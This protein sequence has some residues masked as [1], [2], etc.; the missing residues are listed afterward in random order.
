[1]VRVGAIVNGDEWDKIDYKT[2]ELLS[3]SWSES[4]PGSWA[5][6]YGLISVYSCKLGYFRQVNYG[7]KV[8]ISGLDTDLVSTLVNFVRDNYL[9]VPFA[10]H[11]HLR[12]EPFRKWKHPVVRSIKQT[13]WINL[14]S[15]S[16]ALFRQVDEVLQTESNRYRKLVSFFEEPDSPEN[17][18]VKDDFLIYEDFRG[19]F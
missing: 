12:A 5:S 15:H 6:E 13:Y 7:E 8:W 4:V 3:S 2:M 1:M 19:I 18:K 14:D 10:A 17:A 16:S 9:H 11:F